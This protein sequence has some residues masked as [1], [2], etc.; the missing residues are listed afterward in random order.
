MLREGGMRKHLLLAALIGV[1]ALLSAGALAGYHAF[2]N[3]A[4]AEVISVIPVKEIVLRPDKACREDMT[5]RRKAAAEAE[6]SGTVVDGMPGGRVRE[7]DIP[8]SG[9]LR[10]QAAS[11]IVEKVVGYDVRYRLHG[12]TSKVRMDHDP[13]RQLPV[14]E[15]KVV[16]TVE[17]VSN[18][19][20]A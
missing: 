1:V 6:A 5:R 7:N 9:K 20:K 11:R 19:R 2:M 10:C 12:R 13:G 8:A 18:A 14:K 17:K 3:P 16:L 15:G 4:Y